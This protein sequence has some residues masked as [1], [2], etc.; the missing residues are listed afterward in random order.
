MKK[1][2]SASGIIL[3]FLCLLWVD[4]FPQAG[5]QAQS[6]FQK[7]L[8]AGKKLYESGDHEKAIIKLFEA[9]NLAREKRDL[10]EACFHLSLCYYALSESENCLAYLRRAFEAYPEKDIDERLFPPRFVGFFYQTKRDVLKVMPVKPE[11]KA[12][13]KKIEAEKK[14][15]PEK[16]TD[17][18]KKEGKKV[19]A[20]KIVEPPKPEEKKEPEKKV[21]KKPEEQKPPAAAGRGKLEIPSKKKGRF[22]WLIAGG[23]AL[24]GGVAAILLMK[25]ESPAVPTT[26]NIFIT[27]T[28]TGAKV[29]LD[30]TDTGQTTNCTLTNIAAGT[31]VLKLVLDYYGKW[32]GNVQVVGG[33]TANVAAT[34]SAYTY[35]FVTKWG[36]QGTGDGQFM[37]PSGI[38]IDSSGLVYV[39]DFFSHHVQKFTSSGGFVLKWGR[40]DYQFDNPRGIAAGSSG[41]IYVV[42]Y[43]SVCVQKFDTNGNLI[44]RWGSE[45]SGD[46]QFNFPEGIAVDGSGFVYVA[47]TAN[48]RI[49]KFSTDGDFLTKWGTPGSGDGAFQFPT[50]IAADSSASIY[51][52]D[53]GNRRIQKFS[54]TGVF[55]T[56]WGSGGSLDGQFNYNQD[57]AVD[58]SGYV[59]V[60]DRDNNRIQKFTSTGS[61]FTKWGNL[62]S[63]DGQFD[64]PQGVALDGSGNVYVTDKNNHRIQKFRMRT[65]SPLPAK[66][67]FTPL[68]A[69]SLGSDPGRQPR[70]SFDPRAMMG[71]SLLRAP[72]IFNIRQAP[73]VG[74]FRSAGSPDGFLRMPRMHGDQII[75]RRDVYAQPDLWNNQI[76]TPKEIVSPS[77][78]ALRFPHKKNKRD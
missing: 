30:G 68:R 63:G 51:V 58:N 5:N 43:D 32:E 65:D 46:S 47:D 66:I 3:S 38:C 21:G 6:E 60:V 73:P 11:V 49:Q 18:E 64:S 25:K 33:Q 41:H 77:G 19:E 67:T 50:G 9:Q 54:S 35:E 28:P 55:I 76:S 61:F 72:E 15:E 16:K 14:A 37:I 52:A 59:F 17:L 48:H 2:I 1:K 57:V 8:E 22:P 20:T 74:F 44:N 13:E 71:P 36:S 23:V 26:G 31:H 29:F 10:A 45:G 56:K 4:V 39:T 24:A 12:E 69:D 42:N 75:S 70:F 34:L 78:T 53:S 7:A 62:G 40:D 27:S